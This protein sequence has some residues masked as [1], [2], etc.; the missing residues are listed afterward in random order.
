MYKLLLIEDAAVDAEACQDTVKR[1]NIEAG[2]DA[3][4]LCIAESYEKG[5]AELKND[6]DGVIVDI[7]LDGDHNGNQII[8]AIIEKYRVP[9]AVMTGTPDT[10]LEEGS[11]IRIYKKGETSYED[12]IKSLYR[13]SSTGL[14]NVLGGTG[15][16]EKVMNQIFWMNLYPQISLWQEK[17]EQGIDTEKVLLRYAISH[18]QELMDNEGTAYVTEEMYIKPPVVEGIKTGTIYHSNKDEKYYIVLSPPCDLAVHSGKIKTDRILICE[19]DNHDSVNQEVADKAQKR[20]KKKDNI[21]NAIKNNYTD[22]Y[23]WLPENSL[24]CGGYIN[25][26]KVITFSPAEFVT[27]FERPI[28]KIQEYFVKSIL[29]RFSVYYARQGQPDFD[30]KAEMNSIVEKVCPKETA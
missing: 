9:V 3:F 5:I 27:E 17:K 30:F 11:P 28:I 4:Q 22:Y 19:I 1:M 21:E 24:F 2:E 23:H 13:A 12:I 26:R 15:I 29:N 14:F 10:E 7:K 6:Y 20:D 18:I 8:R 16:I 25:F